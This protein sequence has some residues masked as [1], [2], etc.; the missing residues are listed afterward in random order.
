MRRYE[1]IDRRQALRLAST[2]AA[3]GALGVWPRVPAQAAPP[4]PTAITP[5][6]VAAAAK[7]GKVV[8]YTSVE[9]KLAERLAKAFEA[10]YPAVKVKVER[11]GAERVFQRIGQE[12]ASNIHAVDT[13]NSSDAAHF[14]VWKRQGLLEVV[15]PEDVAKHY[16][17]AFK[18][19]DGMYAAWRIFLSVI[20]YNTKQVKAEEAPK[21]FA[22]LLDPKWAGK[23]V[24]AHPG[25]SGTIMTATQQMARDLGWDYFEKLAKQRI[26]QVQSAVDP[27]KKVILGERPVAVDGGDYS[28]FVEQDKGSPIEVV[29]PTEGTPLVT[30]PSA[31]FKRA[32]NPNA[33]KLFYCWSFTAEAQQLAVDIGGLRS[34]HALVS[35]RKG[36]KPLSEI[37]TM[38]EDAAAVEKEAT[39]IKERY[40]ALFKV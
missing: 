23:L 12:Y 17:P 31:V 27:M 38:K 26:M 11:T 18:D 35:E 39:A 3:A 37:K 34:A 33:A 5:E 10:K 7:E 20:T 19:P 28:V 40:A 4:A 24:K 1:G 13:V 32:P 9:L 30:G 14:I 22:D 6:L 16:A 29:Y 25:Y 36:R 15:E 2:A 21:S 8:Y